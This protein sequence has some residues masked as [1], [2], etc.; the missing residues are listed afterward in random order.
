[1][2]ITQVRGT[3]ILDGSVQ[4]ADLDT[5]TAGS[6]VVRKLIAGTNIT[7]SSTGVDAGTGDVTVNATGG[8]GG[9]S[10]VTTGTAIIDFGAAPGTN[11]VSVNVTGQTGILTTSYVMCWINGDDSTASHNAYEH[12]LSPIKVNASAIS[13]GVGFTINAITDL[14]L[15][16]T[17]SVRYS[18]V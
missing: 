1:M 15:T 8:A 4:R 13:S 2:A 12:M 14:R 3:N 18:W 17:F 7:F 11:I 9:G 5:T 16:G 10:T 6:A